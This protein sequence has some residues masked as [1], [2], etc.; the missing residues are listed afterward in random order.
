MAHLEQR[1]YFIEVKNNHPEFFSDKKVLDI[2]SL[3]INGNNNHLFTNCDYTGLDIAEGPNVNVISLAHEYDALDGSYDV[4]ISNDCFEHDMFYDKTFK[5]INRL[6]K[7]GGFF[8]FTCKTTGSLEHGTLRSD[9]GFSS[10]LTIKHP[11]WAN[12]YKNITEQDVRESINVDDIF[13]SYEFST[14]EIT[15]DI[16]FWGIKK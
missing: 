5:N 8:L 2:G 3:D 14:L 10:P 7:S 12:Y 6:L 13:S 9:G 4:I 11:D 15:C 16:R 1:Q